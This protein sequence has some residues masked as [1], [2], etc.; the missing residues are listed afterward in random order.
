MVSPKKAC[1]G[2]IMAAPGVVAGSLP[3]AFALG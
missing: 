3:K 1:R 2:S